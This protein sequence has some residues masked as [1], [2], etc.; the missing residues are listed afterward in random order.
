LKEQFCPK[1]A[2]HRYNSICLFCMLFTPCWF[3]TSA[4]EK[5]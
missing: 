4:I 3:H 1:L 5:V 2:G